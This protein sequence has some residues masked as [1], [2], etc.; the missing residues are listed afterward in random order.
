MFQRAIELGLPA[1]F[2]ELRHEATHREPPSLIVLR[3]AV[4]RA[5]VWLWGFYW[6][7]IAPCATDPFNSL[8]LDNLDSVESLRQLVATAYLPKK[9][10][11]RRSQQAELARRLGCVC[12]SSSRARLLSHALVTDAILIPEDRR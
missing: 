6:A 9:K 5:L 4:Q 2:V 3:D 12:S 1:S 7:G 8:S 11:G 10:K